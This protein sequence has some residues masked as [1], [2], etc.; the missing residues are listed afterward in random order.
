M[1][2]LY[3]RGWWPE[4]PSFARMVGTQDGLLFGPGTLWRTWGTRPEPWTAVHPK[5][6][7]ELGEDLELGDVVEHYEGGEDQ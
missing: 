2:L 7:L 4:Q 5:L 3:A 1:L 6:R